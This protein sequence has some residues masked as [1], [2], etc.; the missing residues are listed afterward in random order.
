MKDFSKNLNY[1]NI[2][3]TLE[4][5]GSNKSAINYNEEIGMI[6]FQWKLQHNRIE[7]QFDNADL[8]AYVLKEL[9]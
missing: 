9:L 1:I 8:T 5:K 4:I 6:E 2:T 3:Y 7:I